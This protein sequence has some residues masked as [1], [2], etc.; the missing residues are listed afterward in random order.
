MALQTR[1]PA[2]DY[3]KES[4]RNPPE[5]L[6]L[7]KGAHYVILLG[8]AKR[9]EMPCFYLEQKN[10]DNTIDFI[11][12]EMDLFSYNNLA[13]LVNPDD[14]DFFKAKFYDRGFKIIDNHL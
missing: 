1:K 10:I 2:E 3:I 14:K 13:S 9:N 8:F 12:R 4:L 7:A 5:R 11:E 6:S